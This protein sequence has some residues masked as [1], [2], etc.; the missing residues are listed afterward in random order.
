MLKPGHEPVELVALQVKLGRAAHDVELVVE[1]VCSVKRTPIHFNRFFGLI[2]A[3]EC[4]RQ[5]QHDYGVVR[6]WSDSPAQG[7]KPFLRLAELEAELGEKL[8]V[9]GVSRRGGQKV[10]A[11]LEGRV[12]AA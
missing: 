4:L 1:L 7:V 2:L 5:S 8:V 12:D 10:S 6:V 3:G 9:L 11:G